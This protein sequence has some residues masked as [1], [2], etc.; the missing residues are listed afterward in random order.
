MISV[1]RTGRTSKLC[2]AKSG[3]LLILRKVSFVSP[4]HC[5]PLDCSVDEVAMDVIPVRI[6]GGG[7]TRPAR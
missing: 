4:P 2:N 7:A 3:L 5:M 1:G 6:C